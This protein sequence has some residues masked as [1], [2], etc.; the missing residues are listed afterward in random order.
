MVT[1][2]RGSGD[3]LEVAVQS[4]FWGHTEA[5]KVRTSIGSGSFGK[6]TVNEITKNAT[7]NVQMQVV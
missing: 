4:T 1:P 7:D 6:V 2:S 5:Q 3:H